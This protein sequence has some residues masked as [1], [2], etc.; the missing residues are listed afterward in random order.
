MKDLIGWDEQQACGINCAKG[1]AADDL[2]FYF[3][4]AP[5]RTGF[6]NPILIQHPNQAGLYRLSMQYSNPHFSIV[7]EFDISYDR[8]QQLIST[9]VYE[10]LGI[11]MQTWDNNKIFGGVINLPQGTGFA[12]ISHSSFP[13]LVMNINIVNGIFVSPGLQNWYQNYRGFLTTKPGTL[14]FK[15]FDSAG[16]IVG[17]RKK[18]HHFW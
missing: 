10:L 2:L 12:E 7:P 16:K 5:P 13:N 3:G 6:N 9:N 4:D 1:F 14:N 8:Y 18:I 11:S 17:T 15:I